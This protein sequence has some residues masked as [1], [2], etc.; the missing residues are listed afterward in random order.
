MPESTKSAKDRPTDPAERAAADA[1]NLERF[2]RWRAT[3]D[4]VLRDQLVIDPL[5]MPCNWS[6]VSALTVPGPLGLAATA[7]AWIATR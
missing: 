4:T 5:K 6:L 2:K 7:N 1:A 3:G